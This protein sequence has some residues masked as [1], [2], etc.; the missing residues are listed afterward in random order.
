[1]ASTICM[2]VG[3]LGEEIADIRGAKFDRRMLSGV[4]CLLTVNHLRGK[5][6]YDTPIGD[7]PVALN[8]STMDKGKVWINELSIG[9]SWVGFLLIHLKGNPSQILYQPCATHCPQDFRKSLG[10]GWG[11][12]WK[13]SPNS[14]EH[15]LCDRSTLPHTSNTITSSNNFLL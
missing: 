6:L 1:M 4:N 7:D 10:F 9:R 2:Q 13:S 11:N 3:L 8:L 5:R 15:H 14:L 12:Q